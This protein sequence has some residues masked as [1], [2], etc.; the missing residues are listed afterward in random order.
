MKTEELRS[1]Q[2]PLKERYRER[3]ETALVI[4]RAEGRIGTNISCKVGT[5]RA[6]VEAGYILQP[7]ATVS[8]LARATCY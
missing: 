8:W 3:P 2:A 6:L 5:G 4:L 7:A 1:L